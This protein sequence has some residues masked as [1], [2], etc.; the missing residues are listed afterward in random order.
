MAHDVG[1]LLGALDLERIEQNIFRGR[2]PPRLGNRQR[3][4][5][6]LVVAQALVATSRTVEDRVPHSLHCYFILPGDVS[7]PIVYEV[8]RVR[9]G[10]S[11]TTRRCIAVQGGRVIFDFFASFQAADQVTERG[12]EHQLPKPDVPNPGDLPSSADLEAVV[13]H[14]MPPGLKHWFLGKQAIEVRPCDIGRYDG[15]GVPQ[16]R[17]Q[18]WVRASERLPDD[19]A[20]HR[21]VLAYLSDMTLLDAALAPHGRTLFEPTLAAASLDHALWF[22]R[23]FRADEWLLYSQDSPNMSG[24]RGL[25]RGLIFDQAGKLVATVMQE[26]LIRT[27]A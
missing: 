3:V 22:H 26:G 6:G 16:N 23:P 19:P 15:R 10:R 12:L 25:T 13:G 2:S 17:Q 24:S 14:L 11:F 9:D 4:F 7:Q 8:D 20:V 5:G 18:V 21:A 27:R 1:E